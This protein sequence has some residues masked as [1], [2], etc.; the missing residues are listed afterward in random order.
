MSNKFI[1]EAYPKHIILKLKARK[2]LLPKTG[3]EK[4]E[5]R[6]ARK[7]IFERLRLWDKE[8][9][10]V[11][12]KGGSHEVH[13]SIAQMAPTWSQFAN[14]RFDFG[15]DEKKKEYRHW[16]QRDL[17]DIRIGFEESGYWSLVGTEAADQELC[18][19]GAISL[20]L[21]GFDK[22]LPPDWRRLVLHE[23]GH[24]LGFHHEHQTLAL[25]CDFEFESLYKYMYDEYGW[26][27]EDVDFNLKQLSGTGYEFSDHDRESIMHYAFPAEYY[28][29]GSDSPCFI[30]GENHVLSATDR[31][32]A[33]Q[34]YPFD[35]EK[36]FMLKKSFSDA[37]DQ[38]NV[39]RDHS[40]LSLTEENANLDIDLGTLKI[41]VIRAI[42]EA[43]G[44]HRTPPESIDSKEK[45]GDFITNDHQRDA[46][47]IEIERIILAYNP[48]A[49]V[50]AEDMED[51]ETF[52]EYID[53]AAE[54]I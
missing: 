37:F 20:N 45:I 2:I 13:H 28:E 7:L 29:S 49:E 12:F 23:F 17:S 4:P 16:Q 18:P 44:F 6:K 27:K 41:K 24:A 40:R 46:M 48:D 33:E 47:Y 10:T 11:C 52:Q 15:Y 31:A 21:E 53:Y 54:K 43:G 50:T 19:P 9:L 14:I 32:M 8:V 1:L 35:N 26:E 51:F 5:L 30:D 42:L 34:A 3:L 22:R 38:L 36:A 25:K 39:S